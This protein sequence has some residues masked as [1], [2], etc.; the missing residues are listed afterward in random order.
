MRRRS[1]CAPRSSR[2]FNRISVDGECSTNDAV[3]LL[4]N[5]AS[6]APRDDDGLRRGAARGLRE[7]GAP[8]GRGR[9]GEDRPDRG[10][11][12]R[13]RR[14]PA[15]RC[16]RTPRR[17]VAARED[18]GLR[19]RPELGPRARGG[20]LGALQRRLR[21]ARDQPACGWRSTAPPSSTASRSARTRASAAPRSSIELDLRMGAGS[22][23]YLASDLTY[24][25]VR[26]NAEYTT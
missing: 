21:P 22:A 13:R 10:P 23:S 14:R 12:R 1:S 6:G 2:S 5:G 15:G 11:R 9:G 20:G 8:G 25:Y 17:H 4:A 18:G 26:L 24:D 19:A 3:L 7:P 16:D